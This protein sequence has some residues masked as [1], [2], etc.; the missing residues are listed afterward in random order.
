[1][2]RIE[3]R[4]AQWGIQTQ[5]RD[6]FGQTRAVKETTLRRLTAVLAGGREPDDRILPKTIVVR[7]GRPPSVH[8]AVPG[9]AKMRWRILGGDRAAEGESCGSE[10]CL[11]DDLASGTY[12]LE[13]KVTWPAGRSEETATL[14]VAPACAYQ[15][16]PA[17]PR[18]MWGVAAQL[19]GIRSRRNWGHGDFGDLAQLIDLAAA[20]GA[21]AV[22]LNPLH[23]HFDD[24]PENASPYSPNSRLFLNALYIDVEAIPE[25]PGREAAGLRDAVE[26]LR[27]G[28]LIDYPGV[29][30]VKMRGL[31]LA[32][33]RFCQSGNAQRRSAFEHFRRQ[34]SSVTRFA[35]FE[36]LRRRHGKPW[37][38]WPPE[39]Q[40]PGEDALARL[41]SEESEEVGFREFVQWN[42]HEQ[43]DACRARAKALGM[44]IGLYLDIAV[45]VRPEGFDAWSGQGSI[46]AD[47]YIGAPPDALNT[48][49]QNWGLAG[50]NPVALEQAEFEPYRRMLEA[51]MR[52]AGAIRLDHVLALK[53]LFLI[54]KG[55]Q[56]T[57]GTYVNFPFA[58]LL[59]VTAQES[60]RHG[61][62]VIGEDLGTV[63]DNFRET[64]AEWGLWSYQ[65]MMFAR[66]RHGAFAAPE[67]YPENAIAT[68]TTHDLP[69]LAGWLRHHDLAVKRH[70]GLNPSENDEQ[71]DRAHAALAAAVGPAPDAAPGLPEVARY[72]ART[73]SRLVIVSLEDVLNVADQPN[74]PGTTI[75]HPNWRRRLPDALEDLNRDRRLVALGD[76]MA[77]A[78]RSTRR[79][80]EA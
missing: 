51:S 42:A 62:I 10:L 68:F 23:A 33:E 52:Y 7:R 58:A 11:P 30:A 12:R 76:I 39:W 47:A 13:L 54:P 32:Y 8:V 24:S 78:G 65:V 66:D 6:A 3:S 53:R 19:Y 34:S 15:G 72:L 2:N 61:C 70:L 20:H 77:A 17:A 38:D 69:T 28:E 74:V 22:G 46:V 48:E 35:C 63:P 37:W 29:A 45:G 41:A 60:T 1:M 5:Y 79:L 18:R 49:G 43:L 36:V 75:E 14:L 64:L 16:P 67:Q 44:A 57:E 26:N 25:F 59:A 40:N 27:Q 71:R 80:Q 9:E 21:A 55:L 73:P 56:A 4:A 31:R 50:I